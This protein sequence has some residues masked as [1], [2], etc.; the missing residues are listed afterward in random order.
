M[1]KKIILKSCGYNICP[2]YIDD[3][4]EGT[5]CNIDEE[6]EVKLHKWNCTKDAFPENCPLLKYK[7]ISVEIK[8]K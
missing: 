7:K 3:S 6:C 8:E 4:D 5:K 2:F 1:E